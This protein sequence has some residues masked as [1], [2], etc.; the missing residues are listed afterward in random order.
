MVTPR[1]SD[2]P[3]KRL[4][5]W[6]WVLLLLL[7]ILLLAGHR[8]WKKAPYDQELRSLIEALDRQEPHWTFEEWLRSRPVLEPERGQPG[9]EPVGR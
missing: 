4:A 5:W 6:R 7:V 8:Y 1:T 3:Q 9:L 2:I